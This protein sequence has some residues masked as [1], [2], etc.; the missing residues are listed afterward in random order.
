V[1]PVWQNQVEIYLNIDKLLS[2]GAHQDVVW[3]VVVVKQ[4][5]EVSSYI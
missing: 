1:C 5:C 4:N 2:M 3:V